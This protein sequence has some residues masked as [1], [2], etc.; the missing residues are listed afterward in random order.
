MI[1]KR[2]TEE[3]A[4]L[5]RKELEQAGDLIAKLEEEKQDLS[6][7]LESIERQLTAAETARTQR[8]DAEDKLEQEIELLRSHMSLK[9]KK[10]N[11]LEEALM[12]S[13]QKLDEH[14][15]QA[16]GCLGRVIAG[17]AH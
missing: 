9:E 4:E 15:S 16:V 17:T 1:A 12:E 3:Q 11:E 2:K 10:L 8:T 13:D 7:R 5:W 14:L 6:V